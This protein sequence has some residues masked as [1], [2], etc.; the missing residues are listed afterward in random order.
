MVAKDSLPP[1]YQQISAERVLEG[2]TYKRAIR[3]HKSMFKAVNRLAWNGFQRWI[4]EY[5]E[6]KKPSVD[7]LIKGLKQLTDSTCEPE[8]KDVMRSPLFEEVS[9]LFRSYSYHLSHSN[10]KLSKFWMSHVDMNEVLLGLTRRPGRET[11]QC[12]SLLSE[13]LFQGALLMLIPIVRLIQLL[14]YSCVASPE[15]GLFSDWSRNNRY[16]ELS[17]DWFPL[18]QCDFRSKKSRELMNSSMKSDNASEESEF[19]SALDASLESFVHKALIKD[20]QIECIYR[21]VC[22]WRDVLA[23]LATDGIRQE[24][25]ISVN[26]KSVVSYGPCSQRHIKN[27]RRTRF[28]L[29][30]GVKQYLH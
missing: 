21:I 3:F 7:E 27:H 9:Q 12:T 20:V 30:Y 24:S 15:S 6:D 5:Q 19:L 26:S 2:R 16:L 18:W 8:F 13:E 28:L 4:E 23:V 22:R 1:H 14:D 17:Y 29:A 25:Y 10:G 11:G